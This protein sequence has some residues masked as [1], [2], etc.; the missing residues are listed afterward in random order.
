MNPE[1]RRRH[2]RK[3]VLDRAVLHRESEGAHPALYG[4]ALDI[5]VSGMRLKLKQAIDAGERVTVVIH[6]EG[7]PGSF[8]LSGKARWSTPVRGDKSYLLGVE[9]DDA[10]KE[11][12]DLAAWQNL[13]I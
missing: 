12:D 11:G 6:L 9:L 5:S 3:P 13:F 8:R 2:P 10:G 4:T 1:E 7:H